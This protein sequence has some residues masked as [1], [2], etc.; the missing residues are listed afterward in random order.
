MTVALI[1]NKINGWIQIKMIPRSSFI[2]R[3]H[4]TAIIMVSK[5]LDHDK[6]VTFWEFVRFFY[7]GVSS[8]AGNF[9]FIT[10]T[11]AYKRPAITANA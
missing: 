1:L 8:L 6:N 5:Y 7:S 11:S 3:Q 9:N 2:A 10:D 4:R